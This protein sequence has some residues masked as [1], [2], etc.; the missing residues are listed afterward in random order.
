MKAL[1]VYESMFGNTAQ[2]ARAVAAGLEETME[3]DIRDVST[4]PPRIGDPV[5]LI[6]VGAPT[7]AFSLSRPST[8]V[9]AVRQGATNRD[10]GVGLREWLTGL[11]DR[12]H[13]EPV[14][15]FDTRV[16]K[17]RRLP[18]SAAR[19]ATR[20]ARGR[21]FQSAGVESFY[22][23]DTP[24]PLLPGELDRATAWGR[25]LAA[26]VADARAHVRPVA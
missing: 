3:V 20:I 2:V 13:R 14:A 22:V 7:H 10:P 19:K 18:G 8:R 16:D 12:P 24:G 17:V 11:R 26:D 21:G 15:A 23:A 1:L 6:V 25:R 9:D 4:A 5:D